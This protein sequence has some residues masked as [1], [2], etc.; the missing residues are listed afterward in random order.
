MNAQAQT[1]SCFTAYLATRGRGESASWES[2]LPAVPH[3]LI[4][5]GSLF[6]LFGIDSDGL[7]VPVRLDR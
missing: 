1:A 2:C 3:R 5:S 7:I 6:D 4:V